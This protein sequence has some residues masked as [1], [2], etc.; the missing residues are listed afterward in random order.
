MINSPYCFNR[1]FP[2]RIAH[3]Y[4]EF[5]VLRCTSINVSTHVAD[6]QPA[7]VT[8]LLAAEQTCGNRVTRGFQ[9]V[10]TERLPRISINFCE[11]LT[12]YFNSKLYSLA[13]VST[14]QNY[15]TSYTKH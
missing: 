1:S 2:N 10:V 13:I 8:L 14:Q 3:E 5:H 15:K 6:R 9:I 11:H 4:I 7:A 12:D